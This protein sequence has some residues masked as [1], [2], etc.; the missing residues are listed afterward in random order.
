MF[1]SNYYSYFLM[2]SLDL[3]NYVID[4]G[5][6]IISLF[7]EIY[8]Y[9]LI[10][11]QIIYSYDCYIILMYDLLIEPDADFSRISILNKNNELELY[12]NKQIKNTHNLNIYIHKNEDYKLFTN[13]FTINNVTYISE[14][15]MKIDD[16][17]VILNHEQHINNFEN[18]K[19]NKFL[20]IQ[21]AHPNMS[22]KLMIQ[23][24]DH[25]YVPDNDI[26]DSI[27]LKIY[28]S[29][30]YPK[31]RYILDDK[32]N[33]TI[34]DECANFHTLNYNNYIHFNKDGGEKWCIVNKNDSQN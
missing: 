2:K 20:G 14:K 29:K 7:E 4:T 15:V 12:Y 6:Y 30:K 26:L 16:N 1:Y 33:I 24:E 9:K 5:N 13:K 31:E 10:K 23:L 3:C 11:E 34:I 8:I 32:Y 25:H 28:L 21:Y 27:F 19:N 17:P 18:K 22:D